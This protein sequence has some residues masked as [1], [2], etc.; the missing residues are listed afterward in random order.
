MS[1]SEMSNSSE[2]PPAVND[3]APDEQFVSVQ[4]RNNF[5]SVNGPAILVVALAGI[6][7]NIL[8]TLT[9]YRMQMRSATKTSFICLSVTDLV[10]ECIY[11]LIALIMMD[12]SELIDIGLDLTDVVY[13]LGPIVMGVATFASWITAII[14]VERCCCIVLPTRV[15]TLFSMKNTLGLILGMFVFQTVSI[16]TVQSCVSFTLI[17]SPVSGRRKVLLDRS[18]IDSNVYVVL[19]TGIPTII[20]L[21]CFAV[22][23]VSAIFLGMAL[24]QRRRWLQS[25]PNPRDDIIK[26]NKELVTTG[27]ALAFTHIIYFLP[28]GIMTF[29]AFASFTPLDERGENLSLILGSYT[30]LCQALSAMINIYIYL[31]MYSNFKQCWKKVF[32]LTNGNPE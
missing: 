22:I 11:G 28:G 29:I 3:T 32:C 21:I 5:L 23:L 12:M 10:G 6:L 30:I 15:K 16:A 25:L 27:F 4:L 8:N 9:F 13:I 18:K 1:Q 26:R 14:G 7:N 24:K 19:T 17:R 20:V 2:S 31:H